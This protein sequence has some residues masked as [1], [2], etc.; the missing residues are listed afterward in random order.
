MFSEKQRAWCVPAAT[1]ALFAL[2]RVDDGRMAGPRFYPDDPV[3]VDRDAEYDA[4]KARELE[5]SESYDFIENTL[6]SPGDTSQS[7]ALNV[8]TLDEVPD[9]SWFTNR[10]GHRP[11][12]IDEIANG[13]D[14][15]DGLKVDDWILTAGKG[16]GG[17][18]PG[19]RAADVKNPE[20]VFQL[21]VDPPGNPELA[22]AAETIGTALYHAI[23]YN[24]VDVYVV[25]VDPKRIRIS[26]GATIRDASGRRRFRKGDLD[27]VFRLAARNANGT[28]R[29][30]AS[31]FVEGVDLGHFKYY[32]TRPDDPNDIY[33]HEH[34]RE[35]R[36]NRVFCAW[37]NHDDSRA[38]NTLE[39]L[40]SKNGRHYV[41]HYMFDFGSILGSATRFAD[42]PRSGFEY[43]L[44]KGSSLKSLAT[45][46][47]WVPSWYFIDLPAAATPAV[48]RIQGDVFDPETWKAEYPNPAFTNMTPDD[49]FWGARIVAAFSDEAIGAIVKKARFSDPRS[50]D[51]LTSVLIKRRDK[52]AATWL[53]GVN[54]LVDFALSPDG[55]LTFANA[56]VSARASTPGNGYTVSWSRFDNA[57]DSHQAVGAEVKVTEL[58]AQ[59]PS[60]LLTS[61]EFL[62]VTVRG[63]HPDHPAWAKPIR[64]YFRR[65][66][67]G[68]MTV[69]LER[70]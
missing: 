36:A 38:V 35:L 41:R 66:D 9:S 57:T 58:R 18:Q 63:D 61:G 60:E 68:W 42:P 14:T 21:E 12:S 29:M 34:R 8:N 45:L 56:A 50:T 10:I 59:A 64:A 19:F 17:F 1:L 44:E 28:Y 20:Q 54:P 6:G 22:S 11:M 52:I 5:L 31:R 48:G 26:E 40:V 39:M 15:I 23:G 4:A 25:N 3:L 27:E 65:Q 46:G 32:G 67:A 43:L 62:A 51:Y 69:G 55:V 33:P 53:N 37:V 49:A 30:L 2:L 70:N 7:R 13:P 16:P 47:L 24:V